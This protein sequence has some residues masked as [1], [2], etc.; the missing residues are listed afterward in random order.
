MYLSVDQID[1]LADTIYEKAAGAL[2]RLPLEHRAQFPKEYVL[3]PVQIPNWVHHDEYYLL[4]IRFS[5]T[6]S[7]VARIQDYK[8]VLVKEWIME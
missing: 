5:A 1:F 4:H 2:L 6:G 3:P 7:L 8:G